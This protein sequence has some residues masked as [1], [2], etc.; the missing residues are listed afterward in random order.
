MDL[1]IKM[2]KK[3]ST[4]QIFK[5]TAIMGGTSAVSMIAGIIRNKVVAILLGPESI[6][7]LG[8]LQSVLNT[9]G[10]FA[11]MGLAT[12][13]IRQIAE[14]QAQGDAQSVVQTRNALLWASVILGL[15]GAL[16]L[17]IFRRPVA[18]LVLGNEGYAGAIAWTAVGVW[19]TIISGAQT[20]T[21]NGLR[22]LGD[23]TKVYILSALGGMILTVLAVW[24]W[25]EKGIIVALISTPLA[26]L[27]ASRW[28]TLRIPA[29]RTAMS[30]EAFSNPLRGLFSMGF[31]FMTT[32]LI[33]V[34]T[35][36]AV[37]VIFTQTL[38]M[39]A[40]GYFQ[41]A[42]SISMLYLGFVLEA[43]GKDFYPRLTAVARER[44]TTNTMVN[45][46][47][48]LVLLL[49]GPVILGMLTLSSQVVHIIYSGAF[50]ETVVILQWQ[51]IGDLFKVAS[52]PMAFIL[53]AQGRSN[54]FFVTELSWNLMFLGLVWGGLSTWNLKAAG[55]AYLL[56][57]IIYFCT[58]WIIVYRVNRFFWRKKNFFL[59]V[60]LL[61]CTLVISWGNLLPGIF[62]LAL[63]LALTA[64]MSYFS[65]TMISRSLGGLPWSKS[66]HRT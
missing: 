44:E 42:W 6:G 59:L 55:I 52:W 14:A 23:L 56:T 9:A 38:G 64:S 51:L 58:L 20:A 66:T 61:G 24:Q 47:I 5:A 60:A 46:Q 37:R 63:G 28:F 13:G 57:Y 31:T 29:I 41:A 40:T 32:S 2:N 15:L 49:A 3:N 26:L 39:V 19:A 65:F 35:Q 33:R 21:L 1:S 62:P 11:G 43:M 18:V 27:A 7:L 22:R 4:G 48:K 50:S 17:I 30:W 53:V 10:T 16:L 54:L 8:L 45:E 12:S 25:G 34:A 36:L